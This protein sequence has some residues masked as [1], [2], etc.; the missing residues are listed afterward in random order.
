MFDHI[1][2]VTR[3][4]SLS[5]RFYQAALPPLG[6][7]ET[8][9]QDGL[10]VFAGPRGGFLAIGSVR[11]AYWQAQHVA[12][13]GPLHLCLVA[14]N[15]EAVD[16]FHHAAL[17]EGGRDIGAPGY[18]GDGHAYYAAFV[19]DPDGNNI[20]AAFRVPAGR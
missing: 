10:S 1:G 3:D 17:A 9:S 8:Q 15:K 7:V 11:P 4:R 5:L 14:P 20:E 18:R 6:Y 13:G 12:G 19:I 2:I 16:A